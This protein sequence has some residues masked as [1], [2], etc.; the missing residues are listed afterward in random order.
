[1]DRD[2]GGSSGQA[3]WGVW[4]H[5]WRGRGEGPGADLGRGAGVFCAALGNGSLLLVVELEG[6]RPL[7]I[8]S[9]IHSL[10]CTNTSEWLR[11]VRHS[12]RR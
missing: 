10:M 8:H 11:G 3:S 6:L 4:D 9:F 12:A 2:G 5:G 1:M 7:V